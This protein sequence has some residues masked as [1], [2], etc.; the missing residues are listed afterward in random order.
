MAT[1]VR[2]ADRLGPIAM[3]CFLCNHPVSCNVVLACAGAIHAHPGPLQV[4]QGSRQFRN[5][6]DRRA[7]VSQ[8]PLIEPGVM[9]TQSSGFGLLTWDALACTSL[10]Q[11]CCLPGNQDSLLWLG[12]P[13]KSSLQCM[14]HGPGALGNRHD[15]RPALRA[16]APC[17]V[18]AKGTACLSHAPRRGMPCKEWCAV[19]GAL[20]QRRACLPPPGRAGTALPRNSQPSQ[21]A[22][23][24]AVCWLVGPSSFMAPGFITQA[25]GVSPCRLGLCPG[26][27]SELEKHRSLGIAS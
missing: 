9:R 13:Q 21:N 27:V 20:P 10:K 6:N 8:G 11:L 1:R 22:A 4:E 16:A 24:I 14:L 12:A 2:R 23:C 18:R 5:L 25:Q 26:A 7:S 19:D 3:F 17:A 15:S